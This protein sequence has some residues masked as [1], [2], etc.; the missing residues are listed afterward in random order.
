M[1]RLHAYLP[2]CG[3]LL[4]LAVG[5]I[6]VLA[7]PA[8][9]PVPHGP[10]TPQAF[11][12]KGDGAHDDSPAFAE[13]FAAAFKA[14]AKNP[15]GAVGDTWSGLEFTQGNVIQLPAGIYKLNQAD[16]GRGQKFAARKIRIQG[17]GRDQTRIDLPA[18][19]YFLH[20]DGEAMAI[21][22]SDVHVHGG[23]GAVLLSSPDVVG[24]LHFR[25]ERNSF[26]GFTEAALA[27][28][29]SRDCG[30]LHAND[31]HFFA[32]GTDRVQAIGIAWS[33]WNDNTLI[34]NNAFHKVRYGIKLGRSNNRSWI[35]HNSF[36]REGK[37]GQHDIWIVPEPF[38][39]RS[40]L[41]DGSVISQ[42]RF[43]SE[44]LLPSD[45][46]ILIADEDTSSGDNFLTRA[47]LEKPSLG[48]IRKHVIRDNYFNGGPTCQPVVVSFTKDIAGFK[49]D[50][51]VT[52]PPEDLLIV[53]KEKKSK[54]PRR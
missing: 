26:T 45:Y 1:S 2:G 34:E 35:C 18:D 50:N 8:L 22:L 24:R 52:G 43:G 39:T 16:F 30:R 46:R 33:G 11:G 21:E 44:N 29:N 42:N 5:A 28:I 51:I 10:L 40:N 15:P 12:A 23:K 54:E 7:A 25:F 47:H 27:Q 37:Y 41:G 13:M 20:L 38:G 4:L 53:G 31:N 36:M 48:V 9:D 17:A 3:L 19:A 6:Y 49:L 14:P 32:A